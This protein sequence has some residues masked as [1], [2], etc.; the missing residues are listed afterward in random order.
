MVVSGPGRGMCCDSS[1]EGLTGVEE[2]M[3]QCAFDES[4]QLFKVWVTIM[5][6]IKLAEVCH[7]SPLFR[8]IPRSIL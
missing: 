7:D 4:I 5:V 8:A 1:G 2:H 3:Q 6:I